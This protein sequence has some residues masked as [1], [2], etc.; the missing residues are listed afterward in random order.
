MESTALTV[1]KAIAELWPQAEPS[2]QADRILW[3]HRLDT[4]RGIRDDIEQRVRDLLGELS[5][6]TE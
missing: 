3:P 5:V 2:N 6:P 4:V 1:L